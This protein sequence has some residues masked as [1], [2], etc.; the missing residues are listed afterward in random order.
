MGC[1][2][3]TPV[4]PDEVGFVPTLPGRL[5]HGEAIRFPLLGRR[6][7]TGG[8][9]SES[10]SEGGEHT[11]ALARLIQQSRRL[12]RGATSCLEGRLRLCASGLI[13][14]TNIGIPTHGTGI[15]T[16]ASLGYTE[17]TVLARFWR[18]ARRFWVTPRGRPHRGFEAVVDCVSCRVPTASCNPKTD[19]P[20]AGVCC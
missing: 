8:G 10:L 15:A 16:R 20:Q 6:K 1:P 19:Q 12:K 5:N 9:P 3:G 4:G 13:K 7:A 14:R 17:R 2:H 18:R 11:V